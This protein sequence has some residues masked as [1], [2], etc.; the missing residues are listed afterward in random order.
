M[1]SR[2]LL[3]NA[4]I[5]IGWNIREEAESVSIDE[6]FMFL[7]RDKKRKLFVTKKDPANFCNCGGKRDEQSCLQVPKK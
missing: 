1:V 6:Q 5:Q 4:N 2:W 3:Q 7:G